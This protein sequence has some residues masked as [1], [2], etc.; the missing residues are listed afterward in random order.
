M[1]FLLI[2]VGSSPVEYRP[3]LLRLSPLRVREIQGKPEF[4]SQ[5]ASQRYLDGARVRP[6]QDRRPPARR[7]NPD[8]T[9]APAHG[10][11]RFY[12]RARS[13][14]IAPPTPRRP[15][16]RIDH[17]LKINTSSYVPD[18]YLMAIWPV[19]FSEKTLPASKRMEWPWTRT[20]STMC[21]EHRN[22]K[23]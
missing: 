19:N 21:R 4:T 9:N 14:G 13:R 2:Q 10:D 7:R 15:Q 1:I 3:R 22:T 6:D 8:F 23:Q 11:A 16:T 18:M 17:R 5:R 12:N 20:G